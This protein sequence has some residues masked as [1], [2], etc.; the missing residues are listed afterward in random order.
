MV[1]GERIRRR[2]GEVRAEDRVA[3]MLTGVVLD[4]VHPYA[5]DTSRVTTIER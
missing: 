5:S 2:M 3:D 4:V 1:E